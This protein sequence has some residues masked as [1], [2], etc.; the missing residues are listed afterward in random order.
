MINSRLF[1][2]SNNALR[3]AVILEERMTYDRRPIYLRLAMGSL[4]KRC[5]KM[6]HCGGLPK[7]ICKI[8]QKWLRI[9][10]FFSF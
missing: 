10:R 1:K 8:E 5:C 6:T 3:C 7:D 4:L 9:Y 2:C